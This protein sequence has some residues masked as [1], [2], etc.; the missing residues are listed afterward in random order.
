MSRYAK[1]TTGLLGLWFVFSLAAG[2]RHLYQNAA[3]QPPLNLGLA[4]GLPI[5][6][7]VVWF[8]ASKTFRVFT[9]S[10]NPR[11]LTMVQGWRFAGIAFVALA[12]Y[13]ILPNLFAAAAG[14]GDIFIGLTAFLV[15]LNLVSAEHRGSFIVWQL[16]GIVDLVNAVLLGT[17]S[18]IINPHGIPTTAMTELPMSLIPTFGVPLFFILHVICIAQALRWPKRQ[19]AAVREPLRSASF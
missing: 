8:A 19:V 9:L 10:L 18:G 14:Y 12:A 4:V 3:N 17:V 11:T 1:L 6:L 16:L 5:I 2:A 15:A 7:F 13:G